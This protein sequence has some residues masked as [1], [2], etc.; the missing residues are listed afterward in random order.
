MHPEELKLMVAKGR[1][2]AENL[3]FESTSEL[4]SLKLAFR[5]QLYVLRFTKSSIF[6]LDSY[7]VRSDWTYDTRAYKRAQPSIDR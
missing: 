1:I 2:W 7:N 4:Q 3:M 5:S 6:N